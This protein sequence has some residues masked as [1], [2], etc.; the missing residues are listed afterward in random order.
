MKLEDPQA[1]KEA[2]FRARIAYDDIAGYNT[3]RSKLLR[4]FWITQKTRVYSKREITYL[5]VENRQAP[6]LAMMIHGS[7]GNAMDWEKFL[8]HDHDFSV[9]AV[10]RPGYGPTPQQKP[11]LYK[12]TEVLGN[13]LGDLSSDIKAVLVGHSLGAGIASRLAADYP[14]SVEKLVLVGAALI[15]DKNPKSEAL[16]KIKKF[17]YKLLNSR[18]IRHSA[19]ELVAS[20]QFLG[21]LQQRLHEVTCPV[22]MIHAKNDDFVPVENVEYGRGH[23]TGSEDFQTVVLEK[24]GHYLNISRPDVILRAMSG[25]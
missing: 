4:N 3:R 25:G 12:D 23:F 18:S 8:H 5:F 17:P 1:I 22:T 15:P 19:D 24:G 14:G 7:P 10:D 9:C 16:E 20:P 13:L 11:D 2:L 21:N 6:C